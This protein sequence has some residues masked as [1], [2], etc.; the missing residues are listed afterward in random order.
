MPILPPLVAV[1]GLLPTRVP[2]ELGRDEAA[3]LARE[4]LADPI[5]RQNEPSLVER[6]LRWVLERVD[7]LLDAVSRNSPGGWWGVIALA[8]VVGAVVVAVRWRV[9]PVAAR[10]RRS[11]A[12]FSGQ[13]RTAAD[14]R[15]DAQAH[16]AAGEWDDAVRE[17][18]RAVVR[19][20]EE[21]DVLDVRPGRTADEAAAEGG[22][23]IP[24]AADALR[25]AARTFDDVWFG[26]HHADEAAYR[27]VVVA[28]DAVSRSRATAA[29]TSAAV[30][31]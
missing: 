29:G 20:L 15:R 30:A 17:R 26:G 10:R 4:E 21:R 22:R 13:A 23:A 12:L 14:H 18:L 5:Y 6:V 31:P 19:S 3:A 28:D 1:A 25:A 2:V 27:V 9:G 24:A 11:T 16:A 8:V 7:E